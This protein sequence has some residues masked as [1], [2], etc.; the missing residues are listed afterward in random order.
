MQIRA[1]REL[2]TI[3]GRHAEPNLLGLGIVAAAPGVE[4][5]LCCGGSSCWKNANA[6]N[7]RI[8]KVPGLAMLTAR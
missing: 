4:K 3:V 5:A 7:A 8:S 1:V 6:D 2:E